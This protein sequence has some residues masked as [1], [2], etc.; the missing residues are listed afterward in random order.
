MFPLDPTI[1][2]WPGWSKRSKRN[3]SG[4]VLYN[5]QSPCQVHK[6]S[7]SPK[8][9]LVDNGDFSYPALPPEMALANPA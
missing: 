7:E 8:Q 1:C 6:P 2:L 3:I 4:G 5:S 9:V